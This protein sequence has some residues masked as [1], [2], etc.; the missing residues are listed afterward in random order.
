LSNLG[1]ALRTRF[2]RGGNLADLNAE[3]DAHQAAV[4][5]V[6]ASPRVRVG[7][8]RGWARA[9]ADAGRWDEAV[10]GFAAAIELLGQVAPRVLGRGDQE[11]LLAEVG[12]LGAD[13]AAC[14]VRAGLVGQAV[15]LFEQGRG[16][17]LGQA[18]DT[19]TDL[20]ILAERHPDLAASFTGLRDALD[21]ANDPARPTRHQ[22]SEGGAAATAT[23]AER[24]ATAVAFDDLIARIRELDGF[25]GFLRPPPVGELLAT[26]ADGPVVVVAVSRFGSHALLLTGG[27][28][29][30][31]PLAGLTPQTVYD[32]VNAFLTALD[33][34]TSA[35]QGRVGEILGWLWDV[36]AGP[37]LDR[38]GIVG[39]TTDGGRW[40]RLWW[41]TSGLLSFLPV[42]AAGHH[43]TRFDPAPATVLDRVIP[44]YTPTI[45]ALAHTRHT[46]RPRADSRVAL[47]EDGR[48]VAVAMPHTP[49]APDLPGALA[50]TSALQA[51]FPGQVDVLTGPE[52]TRQTVLDRLPA[53][54]WAHFACHGAAELAD[55]STSRLLLADQPLTVLDVA[56]LQ[57]HD[58]ELAFLSACSTAMP[59]SRLT[60][61]AIHLASAFQ[62]AGYRHVIAALW[63]IGDQHAVNIAHDIYTTLTD[64][65]DT[66]AAV[67]TAARGSRSLWA[68]MP[69]VWASHIHVGA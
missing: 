49:D 34:T 13:A 36:L 5:V 63:P 14:C 41:C 16:V 37:V 24:R 7:A 55:P 23:G 40:P 66:A 62:L 43:H 54:R 69:A 44:S 52:A 18:L 25:A 51:R 26:A 1:I 27:G 19:R 67:H 28:V 38:L 31:V 46:G 32:Q 10:T 3:I 8:A 35:A 57:L 21:R 11:Y 39:P 12:S 17:M 15:E 65:G 64:S 29:E 20:T 33:D 42:H 68:R 56:R 59:G 58:A 22:L 50:E 48:L 4:R 60:D 6:G 30:A 61:E 47:R 2:E 9:A 45:R 53:G